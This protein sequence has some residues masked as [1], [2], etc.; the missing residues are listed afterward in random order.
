MN[1]LSLKLVLIST[2]IG[3]LGSGRGGGV[4]VTIFS[5]IKGLSS[6]GHEI[7]L[8]APENSKLPEGLTNIEVCLVKGA[9]QPSWQHQDS[10]APIIIP[11]NGVL[12][13]LLEKALD[14]GKSAD[15]IINFGYDWLPIWLTPRLEL[16]VF[17][18]ISMGGVSEA[19]QKLIKNLSV[20]YQK[21]L[22]FHTYRQAADYELSCSP[23]IVGNGFDL[24][25]YDFQSSTTG[26]LGWA[27]RV[28]PEKGLEDAV[29]I[30]KSFGDK[31]LVWGLVED[32]E[33]AKF[34]ES[35]LPAGTIDWRGFLPT[36]E[37]QKELGTCRA[38]L[39]TPKWNEAYG[40]VVVEAMAC[41]VPV[42]AFDRGGPGEIIISGITGELVPP[43]DIEAMI[44]ATS[45]ITQIKRKECRLWTEKNASNDIFARRVSEW[46]YKGMNS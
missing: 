22:A 13:S 33:Y 25:Q 10:T 11:L 42:V 37:F 3:Y 2:P 24:S 46:I 14:I 41:G 32:N 5:L 43:D 6:L 12:P 19:I 26:P 15:A 30:A 27:G 40:N 9:D 35:S 36:S 29:A 45:R 16:P 1:S 18:L 17:H 20:H 8:V 7:I 34:V 38:L 39:N 44:I 28:A 21:R 4:E 23:V 31:L